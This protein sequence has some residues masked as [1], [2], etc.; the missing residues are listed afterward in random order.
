MALATIETLRNEIND[1]DDKLIELFIKRFNLSQQ[2]GEVKKQTRM[3]VADPNR[4]QAILNKIP[5]SPYQSS[6]IKI[7]QTVFSESKKLQ[8][9]K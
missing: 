4:E 5:S 8:E 1:I 2:I 7:Y 9:T 3:N 6:L